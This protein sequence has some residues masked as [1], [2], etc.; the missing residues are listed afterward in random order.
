[1]SIWSTF[2]TSLS[3]ASAKSGAA[4]LTTFAGAGFGFNGDG[5]WPLYTG[6]DD[7]VALAVDSVG[8]VYELDD[9]DHRLRKIQ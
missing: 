4:P 8:A 9:W 6:F 3:T 1:L 7:P 5:L 2:R